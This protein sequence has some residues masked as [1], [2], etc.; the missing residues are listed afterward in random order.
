MFYSDGYLKDSVAKKLVQMKEEQ[1]LNEYVKLL[2]DFDYSVLTEDLGAF[3][4]LSKKLLSSFTSGGYRMGKK[5]AG[6]AAA[7]G[8]NSKITKVLFNNPSSLEKA[9]VDENHPGLIVYVDDRPIMT[10]SFQT[11]KRFTSRY[12]SNSVPGKYSQEDKYNLEVAIDEAGIDDAYKASN[13]ALVQWLGN[14]RYIDRTMPKIKK[15]IGE[16]M[17]IDPPIKVTAAL[18]SADAERLKTQVD[19]AKTRE[20][21][22]A[23]MTPDQAKKMFKDALMSKLN[24]FKLSKSDVV[25]QKKEE[26]VKIIEEKLPKSFAIEA[27]G[28]KVY[29]KFS[30][31]R[32]IENAIEKSIK[33]ADYGYS[34]RPEDVYAE[35]RIDEK[36]YNTLSR[37]A[38]DNKELAGK[39][40][41]VFPQSIK[42][43]MT[44]D[45]FTVKPTGEIQHDK[46]W[47]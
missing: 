4:S 31:T 42:V 47:W 45:G 26:I 24:A 29:Y 13:P 33:G 2:E 23:L 39:Y 7:Y 1:E 46:G 16:L 35:F 18:V 17:K 19:R 43:F 25:I 8:Q 22:V 37:Q 9:M 20:G 11:N 21:A 10:V 14:H 3:K 44:V 6:L 12:S 27:D 34:L 30:G 15:A 5:S 28:H 38:F 32:G 40:K 41:D 36:S